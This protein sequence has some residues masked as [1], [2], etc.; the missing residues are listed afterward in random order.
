MLTD[1]ELQTLRNLGDLS[2]DAAVEIET[3]RAANFSLAAG[4][5]VVQDGLLGDEGGTPYCS[6]Q[7]DAERY[8]VLTVS[9]LGWFSRMS[10][11]P[12]GNQTKKQAMDAALDKLRGK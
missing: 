12:F 3:L 7:A 8:R 6:L 4:T 9:R 1:R 2:E 5:C 10:P 11:I